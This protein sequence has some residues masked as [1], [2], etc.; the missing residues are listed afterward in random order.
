MKE[1]YVDG[2]TYLVYGKDEDAN[3][4]KPHMVNADTGE[5]PQGAQLGLLLKYMDQN[6][7]PAIEGATTYYCIG[8]ILAHGSKRK[9]PETQKNVK[10]KK[11]C[12]EITAENLEEQ[13]R[14]VL[15][16]A[17]Y[18][19]ELQ[20]IHDVLNAYPKNDDI[21]TIAMKIAVIDV[22]NSTHLAQYKSELSLYDLAKV[23]YDI[24]D[25]DARVQ[26]G[27]PQLVNIIAKNIGAL[28]MFSFASKYCL[29]HNMEIYRRDDYSIYDSVVKNALPHY[30]D[31]ITA[32]KLDTW[33]QRYDYE[34]FNNCIGKLLD[35]H[36]I[37]I[38]FRRRK[39]DHFLWYSNR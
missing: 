30:V 7:I 33:R 8:K 34:S 20:I 14:L 35:E 12:L 28:N 26:A 29:Y 25:F 37:D 18:G 36:G 19:K 21:N 6:N 5:V 32:H 13:H 31:G 16:S 39:F 38:P 23:I 1:I 15:E 4:P 2:T 9:A 22:T 17:N 3:N 27:D 24:P 10:A 11:E